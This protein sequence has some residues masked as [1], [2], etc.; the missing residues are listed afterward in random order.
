[1]NGAARVAAFTLLA[2]FGVGALA[3]CPMGPRER[4]DVACAAAC[5]QRVIGCTSHECERGC[6][7]VLDRLV[8]HEEDSVLHCVASAGKCADE[9]WATCAAQVGV[10]ADGGPGVPPPLPSEF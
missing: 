5:E 6:A 3:G 2:L 8:E 9:Q 1:M 10:H 7:F 4:P